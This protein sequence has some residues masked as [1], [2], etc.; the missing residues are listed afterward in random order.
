MYLCMYDMH[1]CMHAHTHIRSNMYIQKSILNIDVR[2][3][4]C[5]YVGTI[6]TI[7]RWMDGW[8]DGWMRK[9]VIHD[10]NT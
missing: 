10:I 9:N 4:L 7:C 6:G 1:V 5:T 3:Q 2:M 8:M